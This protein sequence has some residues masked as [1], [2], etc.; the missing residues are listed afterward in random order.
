MS[1]KF[2]AYSGYD[3]DVTRKLWPNA[4][5]SFDTNT[6]L[7]T[8]KMTPDARNQ[9]LGVL[10][11]LK[12][13]LWM[14]Y[15]VGK[16]F[17]SNRRF[18]IESEL[19]SL[20]NTKLYFKKNLE[21]LATGIEKSAIRFR[22]QLATDLQKELNDLSE[23]ISIMIDKCPDKLYRKEFFDG[24]ALKAEDPISKELF[25]IFGDKVGDGFNPEEL[26]K[27]YAEGEKRYNL[28]IPPGFEDAVNKEDYRK[29][30]DLVIWKELMKRAT[31]KAKP[32][33]LAVSGKSLISADA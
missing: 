20:Q 7:N 29:Y 21:T 3:Y 19:K 1:S 9:F 16:E 25:E 32:T 18:V 4:L 11:T 6:L 33:A 13:R 24:P 2:F 5:I 27:I 31:E 22:A 17:Y 14:P 12:D 8:Y 26:L 28:C 30:G 15:Q 10:Q 23:R